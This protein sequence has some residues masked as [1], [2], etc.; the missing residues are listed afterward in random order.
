MKWIVAAILFIAVMT[1]TLADVNGYPN[2]PNHN[3]PN[4]RSGGDNH[5]GSGNNGGGSHGSDDQ[6]GHH[7]RYP[8]V[9]EPGTLILMATG[10]GA[11]YIMRKSRKAT[12]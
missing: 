10:L 9:P 3:G 11:F 12:A 8:G 4:D 7:N 1:F 5:L 6:P 2:R